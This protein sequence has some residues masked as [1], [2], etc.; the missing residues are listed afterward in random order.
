M[1][2]SFGE[3][4]RLEAGLV[5]LPNGANGRIIRATDKQGNTC[6]IVMDIFSANTVANGLRSAAAP[7]TDEKVQ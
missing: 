5:K 4:T 1:D 3:G 2:I 7:V 6:S